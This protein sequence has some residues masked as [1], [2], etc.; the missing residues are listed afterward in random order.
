MGLFDNNYGRLADLLQKKIIRTPYGRRFTITEAEGYA[1]SENEAPLYRP[2]VDMEPGAVYCPRR[3]NAILTLVACLDDG[4]R[5]GCVLI[6]GLESSA[7]GVLSGPS[8]VSTALGIIKPRMMG[9]L[10]ELPAR[11][12]RLELHSLGT[13]KRG[14]PRSRG[15][16]VMH[17]TKIDRATIEALMPAIVDQWRAGGMKVRFDA[18]LRSLIETYRTPGALRRTLGLK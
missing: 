10:I 12:L 16:R 14:S 5:G 7:D 1:R 18:Y 8:A 6:R 13:T 2:I 17:E 3:R 15:A 4:A 9:R 11:D